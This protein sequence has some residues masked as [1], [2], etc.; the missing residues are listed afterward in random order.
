LTR[1]AATAK[2]P[3]GDRNGDV[4]TTELVDVQATNDDRGI[5]LRQ[6][7]VTALSYPMQVWDRDQKR[8]QVMGRFKLTVDLPHEY[9]GTHMSRFVESLEKHS[10]EMSLET[11]PELVDDLRNRL[12]AERAHVRVEF[13]YFIRKRAPVSGAESSMRVNC[14]FVGDAEERE[15]TFTLGVSVPVMTACPCSKAI[16]E[17][18]AHC[19]RS[20]V[21]MS[22]RFRELVWIEE[23]IHYAE[24]SASAPIFPLLK[25]EDEKWITE[26]SYDNPRFVEDLVREVAIRL[27]DDD[28]I[29]WFYV[30]AENEESI[31][32]HNAFAA[33]GSEDLSGTGSND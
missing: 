22:I 18:G 5:P 20:S 17:R 31:H 26:T 27:R 11:L 32:T 33:V 30:E 14:W 16:S 2:A 25:R 10:G 13:P 3:D 23:L 12:D 15:A 1:A 21:R 8:Q 24:A 6:V 28:R 9:K 4:M 19:Q 7:G 29:T